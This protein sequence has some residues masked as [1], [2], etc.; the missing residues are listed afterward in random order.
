MKVGLLGGMFNPPH[1][2]HLLIA[3]QVLDFTDCEAI[4]FLP[5][6]K[7]TFRKEA[8]DPR[9]RLSMVERMVKESQEPRFSVSSLEIDN[10]L[11][12]N[13]I[14]L[15]PFLPQEHTYHFVIGSDQLPTFHLWGNWKELLKR[16]PFF[17]FPRYGYPNEP[18][19]ENMTMVNDSSLIVSNI[20]STKVRDRVMRRLSLYGFVAPTV[21]DYITEHDLHHS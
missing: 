10:Q 5:S 6:Y 11:D 4:W 1:L 9:H 3:Q 19:Y 17:V 16:L 12:G 15:L 18:L 13:T 7:H 21:N 20:S 14:N 8:V 2:G